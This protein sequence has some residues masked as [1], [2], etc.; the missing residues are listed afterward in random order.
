MLDSWWFNILITVLLV[1]ASGFFVI[2]EF[3]LLG[4]RRN[5]LEE[6]ADSSRASRAGLR[7]LN[8]LTV[9]LAGA[10]L[11]ITAATFLL[12]AI[13]K[14]WVHH[15]LVGPLESLGL[16]LQIADVASFILALFIVTFL[17]L[18]IGEMAPKSWA[19]THPETALQLIAVPARGFVWVFR[20]L[21][22]WINHM[23]NKMVRWAGEEPVDRAGAAGYDADTLRHLVEHSRATGAMDDMSA[24]QIT[25][26]I[27]LE[28]SSVAALAREHGAEV[29][30]LPSDATV[31][32][33]QEL[34]TR[35]KFMRV[36]VFP[37]DSRV[38]RIVH[39]RDTMLADPSEPALD[40]S[41]PALSVSGSTTVQHTLDHM[42]ARNEQ[43]VIVGKADKDKAVWILTWDD[44][45]GQ[46]WPQIEEKLDK[47]VPTNPA[48]DK[49]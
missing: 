12:G 25:S 4:A 41:R 31:A 3:S 30:P 48:I 6:T 35:R 11:G 36:L 23:A 42:R 46:L 10:Q 2:I 39:V 33:L 22:L 26:V 47:V 24:D 5:R 17:H 37:R 21:L 44:I 19:I 43:L 15:L 38:P 13:T 45:M 7:S 29:I 28:A 27:E 40:Y 49:P 32:D 34:V 8:E 16:P 14:P 9:M 20:P 18:V 1:A